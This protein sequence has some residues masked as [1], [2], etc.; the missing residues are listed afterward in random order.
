MNHVLSDVQ[1]GFRKGKG[2]RSNCQHPL[3]DRKSKEIP[4]IYIYIYIYTSASLTIVKPLCGSQQ[5]GKF[6]KKWEYQT[7]L[8]A[9]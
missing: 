8:P 4:N 5:T 7:T 1:A 6:L 2:N 3:D 9:S